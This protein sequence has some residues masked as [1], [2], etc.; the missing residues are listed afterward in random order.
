MSEKT[1]IQVTTEQYRELQKRTTENEPIR[2]GIDRLI[3]GTGV[4][5]A[6]AEIRQMARE[7]AQEVIESYK[8]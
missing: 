4:L 1:T 8:R 3:D 6:E 5:F 7:E 2:K